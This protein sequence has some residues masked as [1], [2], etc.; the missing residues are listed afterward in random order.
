TKDGGFVS[1]GTD[2]SELKLNEQK[3]IENEKRQTALIRDLNK[4]RQ[5]LETQA[6]QLVTLA[7]D[8]AYAKEKAEAASSAKSEFLAN[9]SHELRTPLNAIIGFSEIMR[10]GVFGN[11]GSE[12]YLEYCNDIHDS[13]NFLLAVIND[14]LQMSKIEAGRLT[15]NFE[16]IDIGDIVREA[17]RVM[18]FDVMDKNIT[19]QIAGM[20]NLTFEADRR[21]M[22]QIML[23]LLTNSVK[24]TPDGGIIEVQIK[25][26]EYGAYLSIKDTGIGIPEDSIDKLGMP[27]EQVQNQ[28]TKDHKGSGLG[29]AITK[30]L[31][32]M[33]G[34]HMKITSTEGVGT[35]VTICV[36]LVQNLHVE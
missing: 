23:N 26:G 10:T 14:I 4:S 5:K 3:L 31:V 2:I 34:G 21:A 25:T 12:K 20:E 16:K 11:L 15:L 13:G 28:F 22:K 35:T 29:L 19:M 27:F 8:Y 17:F 1:V 24:F 7:E 30:S 6:Q 32:S 36:P 9:I 33:H 18:N